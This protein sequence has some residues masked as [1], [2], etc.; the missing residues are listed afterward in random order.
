MFFNI[1]TSK[2]HFTCVFAVVRTALKNKG[3]RFALLR[4]LLMV[5][6]PMLSERI[7]HKP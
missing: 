4:F 7:T 6:T 2:I 3:V 1:P 5:Y